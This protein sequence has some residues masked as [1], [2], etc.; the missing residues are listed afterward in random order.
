MKKC[1]QVVSC[2]AF[3]L[4]ADRA[5]AELSIKLSNRELTARSDVIVIGR[6][7]DSSSRE[8]LKD[9]GR[10]TYCARVAIYQLYMA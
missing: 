7:L 6:A 10:R 2:L 5:T 8:T 9:L 3:L 1:A 4:V